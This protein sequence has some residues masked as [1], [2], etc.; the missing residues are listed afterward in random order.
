MPHD[1]RR[2]TEHATRTDCA[3]ARDARATGNGRVVAN[4][5]VMGD[6]YKVVDLD[7]VADHCVFDCATIYRGVRSDFDIVADDDGADLRDFAPAVA[8]G[9]QAE[10][11]RTD[12]GPWMQ[13][14]AVTQS[15]A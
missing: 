13:N 3:A 1:H 2:T 9:L 6:L 7:A 14:A 5:H 11:V 4:A 10:A 12:H 15:N 8:R